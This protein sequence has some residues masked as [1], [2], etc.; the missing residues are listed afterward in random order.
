MN[1]WSWGF[2]ILTFIFTFLFYRSIKNA[3][4]RLF[5]LRYRMVCLI[6]SKIRMKKSQQTAYFKLGS[7]SK[8]HP[9]A[10]LPEPRLPPCLKTVYKVA[11]N[12]MLA[13][14]PSL[15]LNAADQHGQLS[16]EFDETEY[17][18]TK[19]Q[20]STNPL[21]SWNPLPLPLP[22]PQAQ[23]TETLKPVG[24]FKSFSSSG[25]LYTSGPL[26]LPPCPLPSPQAQ[27]TETLKPV[28]SFKSFSGSGLLYT[29]GPLPLPPCETPR[30]ISYDEIYEGNSFVTYKASFGDNSSG[31][32]KY[33]ASG[34]HLQISQQSIKGFV[35]CANA[36]ASLQ[37]PNLCKLIGYH[38]REGL[39]QRA[40]VYERLYHGR[41]DR[42]LYRRSDGPPIDWNT[43]MKIALCAAQG[44]AFLHEEGSSKAMY[45]EFSTS[46]IQID[47]D[48]SA[49]LS[50]YGC[51]GHPPGAD[52]SNSST[53]DVWSF[54]IILLELLT[55]RKNLDSS[56]S[57]EERN[58]VNW[59]R[60][61]LSDDCR[62]SLIM[63]PQLKGRFPPKAARAVA[64]VAKKCLQKDPSERPT[65]RAIV[66][67]L[68]VVQDM[69]YSC[70]FPLQEPAATPAEKHSWRS[71]S[72]DRG[73]RS[74]V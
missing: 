19:S 51:K 16:L 72:V 48:F 39:G 69:K 44:L 1:L 17:S 6:V 63:D 65:M 13:L 20:A 74:P 8:E 10:A 30:S 42:L 55:G 15:T 23:S 46:N 4:S 41:L 5:N 7:G 61:F 54:G 67:H 56:Y 49:K 26:P 62:L 57:I 47:K 32:K 33:G 43:R 9:P 25:L 71:P 27:S 18:Y 29:S 21:Q 12:R 22:S 38:A 68:K 14:S 36:L 59:S 66:N 64:E 31:L 70:R 40:L 73:Y 35:N 53:R 52:I 28:G 60:P 2:E 34:A 37:H 24:S 3:Y 58:L 11:N 50:G 45:N